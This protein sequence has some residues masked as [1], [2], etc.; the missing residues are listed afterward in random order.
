MLST[1]HKNVGVTRDRRK[2]PNKITLYD[3]TKGGVDIVD[4]IS[5]KLSV[6]IKSKRWTINVLVF[7]LDI[8]RTNAKTILREST[9]SNL[10]TFKFVRELE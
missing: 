6:H 2:K 8:V 9:N 5:S 4:F 10:T 7:I 1:I 3:H